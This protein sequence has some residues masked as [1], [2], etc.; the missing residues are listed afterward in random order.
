MNWEDARLGWKEES[1][2]VNIRN[3]GI[4]EEESEESEEE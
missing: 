4:V 3:F 1:E 2:S